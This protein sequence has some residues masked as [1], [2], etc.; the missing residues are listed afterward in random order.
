MHQTASQHCKAFYDTYCSDLSGESIV[1]DFGAY[2]LNGNVRYI[3]EPTM[4]YIG[5]DMEMGPNVDIACSNR[6][7]PFDTK[8]VDRVISTSC[9]EH[10]ACFWMTFLEMCRIVKPGGYIYI[11]APSAGPYHAHPGDCWR[12]YK[13]SWKALEDWANENKYNIELVE[14]FIDERNMNE[15]HDSVGIFKILT[16]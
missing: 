10:D 11:N 3:F 15:W 14:T 1:V 4:K 13:D 2:S 5:I 9:F 8:S 7:T 6:K 16:V 12:F